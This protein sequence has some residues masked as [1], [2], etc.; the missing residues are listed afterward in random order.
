[1]RDEVAHLR[2]L[3]C[4]LGQLLALAREGR[5]QRALREEGRPLLLLDEALAGNG[6][7]K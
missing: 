3:G 4:R 5:V 1:M 2:E 6:P 7:C